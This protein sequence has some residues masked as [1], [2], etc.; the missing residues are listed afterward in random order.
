MTS[1][2]EAVTADTELAADLAQGVTTLAL[3]QVVRFTKYVRVVLP[4][5]GYVFWVR[6]DIVSK[7]AIYNASRYNTAA[8]GSGATVTPGPYV[9]AAGSLHRAV[10]RVQRP[11]AT[12]AANRIVFTSLVNVDAFQE[13]GP[14]AILV[15]E[16]EGQ[17][18]TFSSRRMFYRQA[19]LYHYEG[20][21]I[22]SQ[23]ASQL[24]DSP[25]A[26]PSTDLIVSNSLPIW[27]ALAGYPAP[28]PGPAYPPIVLYPS[29]LVPQNTLPPYGAVH[30]P[31]DSTQAM[32]M[33][34]AFDATYSQSQL[35]RD[36]VEI[37]LYG[38]RNA[39][40]LAFVAA[41]GQYSLD[42]DA[43]GFLNRPVPR[44]EKETQVEFETIAMRKSITFEV[45]YYQA[46][47]RSIARQLILSAIPSIQLAS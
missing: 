26:F 44:D 24:I 34:A 40:A 4:L 21:A 30:I 38:L 18:Y 14:G 46:T 10:Q 35:S 5:D 17:R 36:R 2:S 39:D 8:Y 43:I 31:P 7:S 1:V 27:L 42:T 19:N 29:D 22:Y 16:F 12:F 32:T 6:A 28:V 25:L 15:A 13:I 45:S 20:M 3:N 41:V 47:A 23:M 9:D 37:T 11:E 33:A